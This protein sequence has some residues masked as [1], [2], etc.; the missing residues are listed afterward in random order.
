MRR[1]LFSVYLLI[2]GFLFVTILK[3]LFD[4]NLFSVLLLVLKYST[5]VILYKIIFGETS[6]KAVQK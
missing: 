1:K 6:E 4:F 2:D 5:L 3:S